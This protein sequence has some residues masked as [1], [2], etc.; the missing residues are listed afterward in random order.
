[1]TSL[2]ERLVNVNF[3]RPNADKPYD[4]GA[5]AD[6]TQLT[7]RKV[8]STHFDLLNGDRVYEYYIKSAGLQDLEG[9][10]I[11]HI[12]DTQFRK[13]KLLKCEYAKL[14]QYE[15]FDLILHTGDIVQS[16]ENDFTSEHE[17]FLRGL[18]AKLGKFY[19]LG[20]H[21]RRGKL[22][23]LQQKMDKTGFQELTN[24]N[25]NLNYNGKEFNIIGLDEPIYGQPN[26]ESA[27]ADVNE[28][29]RN[30]VI[31][32]N[33]DVLTNNVPKCIDL[34]LSGHT[35]AGEFNLGRVANGINYLKLVGLFEDLNQQIKGFKQ[36]TDR[37]L[38]FIHPATYSRVPR[39]GIP[40]QGYVI[41]NFV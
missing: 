25:I 41:H 15:Y 28:D 12:S 10:R 9:L 23:Q 36:L 8:E 37:T 6:N 35:H 33:L 38:S 16:S 11:L 21:D 26:I 30:I 3:N 4:G 2:I 19:I 1:M 34:V 18:N 13:N 17:N 27:F 29:D 22:D 31:T 7:E 20:N 32:H 14:L 5:Y 39:I 40:K 24:K